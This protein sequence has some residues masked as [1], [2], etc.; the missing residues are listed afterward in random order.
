[1][2]LTHELVARVRE[3]GIEP[4][5]D[6]V[7]NV[8]ALDVPDCKQARSELAKRG[9]IVSITRKPCALRLV[10]MPHLTS[11]TMHLF[12]DDLCDVVRNG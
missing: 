2:D 9:W 10:I 7:M 12:A 8:V 11:E 3:F 1:M 6:P 5:I 4:L